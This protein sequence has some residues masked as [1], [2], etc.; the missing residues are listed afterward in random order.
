M[1]PTV[2]LTGTRG[3]LGMQGAHR[4]IGRPAKSLFAISTS[5][6]VSAGTRVNLPAFV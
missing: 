1:K 3:T 5:L 6:R 2:S 4:G